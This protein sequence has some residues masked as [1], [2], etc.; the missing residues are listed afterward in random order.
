MSHHH[1]DHSGGLRVAVAEGLRIVTQRA[2]E[3]FFKDLVARKHTI[4]PDELAKN[5]RPLV[6]DLVDEETTLKD[7]VLEVQLYHLVDNPRE[8]TNLFAYV[9]RDH[10]LVQA[11][12]YDSTWL[13][14]PWGANVLTNI[15]LHKLKVDRDVPV[16]GTVEN[17]ADMVKT[18]KAKPAARN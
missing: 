8:G 16:H 18:I 10:M 4:V 1:F 9:P 14:H 5:P 12:L 2:N 11:D 7:S 17:F 13:Q 3:A 6:L 15:D